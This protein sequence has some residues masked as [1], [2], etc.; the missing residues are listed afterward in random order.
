MVT[1]NYWGVLYDSDDLDRFIKTF[2]NCKNVNIRRKE[3][4]PHDVVDQHGRNIVTCCIGMQDRCLLIDNFT[5]NYFA[6]IRE[7]NILILEDLINRIL[8]S[9]ESKEPVKNDR[10]LNLLF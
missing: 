2:S 3:E 4:I 7:E 10:R 6:T 5:E 8:K 9:T 1:W